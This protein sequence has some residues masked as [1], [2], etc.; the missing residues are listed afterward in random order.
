MKAAAIF[1]LLLIP[2]FYSVKMPVAYIGVQTDS[3]SNPVKIVGANITLAEPT[4]EKELFT[5]FISLKFYDD[6]SYKT[7]IDFSQ[8]T[9]IINFSPM[10]EPD[11]QAAMSNLRVNMPYSEYLEKLSEESAE[12]YGYAQLFIPLNAT[13]KA[14][15]SVSIL[16]PETDA[17]GKISFLEIDRFELPFSTCNRNGKCDSSESGVSCPIDCT[18][19]KDSVC[20]PIADNFCD[21][22]CIAGF[23]PDCSLVTNDKKVESNPIF[24]PAGQLVQ[25]AFLLVLGLLA[26]IVVFS[27]IMPKRK[28]N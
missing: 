12:V 26:I 16:K 4:E 11:F 25:S 13:N 8:H 5:H 14:L 24:P 28:R 18:I 27:R 9:A 23:D 22:S 6:S 2:F 21:S 17:E 19:Q 3:Q 15:K 7:K 10:P 1:F 20:T